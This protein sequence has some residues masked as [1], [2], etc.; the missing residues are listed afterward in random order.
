MPILSLPGRVAA[1]T[2]SVPKQTAA[3]ERIASRART[4]R[5][6]CFG[7]A[8][9]W[10]NLLARVM[11]GLHE[12][13]WLG[14][15]SGDDLNTVTAEHFGK[16]RFYRSTEHNLSGFFNWEA[17]LLERHIRQ[18][19]RILV[20]AAGAGRE[21]LALRKAGFYA[22]GFECNLPLVSAG[23]EI[24]E[25]LGE[26]N[27]I[28]PCAADSVPPGPQT[29]DALIIGWSAYT[30]IPT[31]IRRISFLQALRQRAV[32][33]SPLIVSF[34]TRNE[35]SPIENVVYR[36]G[37]TVRFL[38]RGRKEPLEPGDHLEWSRYVHRFTR[39]EL[40]AELRSA[41]F[42]VAHYGEDSETSA[43]AVGYAE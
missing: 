43:Y 24:F 1:I 28:I 11:T 35:H 34:F 5:V 7:H 29:Y 3:V 21:I 23:Q 36:T 13:F 12:G 9:R 18:G 31:K 25:R 42:S 17:P 32:P 16:S 40:E 6:R 33:G 26:A 20:A 19:S 10:F 4:F 2:V 30:H 39:G 41:G 15:L 37:A 27:H 22:E 8:D 38:L 14:C